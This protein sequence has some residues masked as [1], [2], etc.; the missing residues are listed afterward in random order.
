MLFTVDMAKAKNDIK[1]GLTNEQRAVKLIQQ[2]MSEILGKDVKV[3]KMKY[4]YSILDYYV[5][6]ENILI[7]LKSRRSLYS[8]YP[9]QMI[10]KNKVDYANRKIENENYKVY[11]FYLLKND[12]GFDFDLYYKRHRHTDE[13]KLTRL[14]NYARGDKPC[15]IYLI[16]NSDLE[17]VGTIERKIV[18]I[19]S[20]PQYKKCR[21]IK[22]TTQIAA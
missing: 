20:R 16:K 17:K 14:G 7:E 18:L 4:G 19:K 6:G 13:Y 9:T 8:D 12:N 5:E 3:Q 21:K 15:D 22:K 1:Y 11:F 2:K 10:G